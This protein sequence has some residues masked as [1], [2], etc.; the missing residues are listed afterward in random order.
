MNHNPQLYSLPS[1]VIPKVRDIKIHKKG[2]GG[3]R[4]EWYHSNDIN[5]NNLSQC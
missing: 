4:R 3:V 5:E 2:H 1:E